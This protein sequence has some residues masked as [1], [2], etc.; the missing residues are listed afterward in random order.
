MDLDDHAIAAWTATEAGNLL[1]Q[2]REQ[3]LEGRDL[4]DAGD[5]A[6]HELLMRLLAEHRPGDAVLSEEGKDDKARLQADR[7]WIVDPLDGTREFSEPPATTG[8]STWPSG[9]AGSWSPVRSPS[10][11][12]AARG[13]PASHPSY[14]PRALTGPGWS[15]PAP[16]R[17]PS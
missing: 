14:P 8:P 17:P 13:T 16:A 11:A 15:S 7:V 10:P 6:A 5:L 3:G 12:S 9:S 4:K 2:V 1:L